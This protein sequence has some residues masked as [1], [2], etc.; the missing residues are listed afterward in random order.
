VSHDR[1]IAR[2]QRHLSWSRHWGPRVVLTARGEKA[3][4]FVLVVFLLIGGLWVY[5]VPLDRDARNVNATPSEER[6]I[7][8]YSAA[9]DDRSQAEE[10]RDDRNE[11]YERAREEYRTDLD[12][13]AP[14]AKSKR[15]FERART[16]LDTATEDLRQK[17]AAE[18]R[19][20]RPATRDP[21]AGG[22]RQQE[23]SDSAE[24]TTTLLRLGWVIGSLALAFWLFNM[25]RRRRS[26]YFVIGIALIIAATIQALVMAFDY[27]GDDIDLDDASPLVIALVGIVFALLAFA[28][29]QR[30]LARRAPRRRVRKGQCPYCAYPL[31]A[32]GSHCEGCGRATIAPCATC[33]AP[34]R[35]GTAHCGACGAA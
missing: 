27:L 17:T 12:A 24:R 11:A 2:H 1:R 21:R 3:L 25:L 6:A 16:Q 14:A 5:F 13:N 29:L 35:V 26:N 31:T 4:A 18:R 10:R 22:D 28:G 32:T 30:Y 9:Q 34:R 33:E 15:A 20:E 8:D 23:A 19:L 7:R